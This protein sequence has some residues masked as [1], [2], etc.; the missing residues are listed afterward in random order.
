MRVVHAFPATLG[1]LLLAGCPGRIDDPRPFLQP[2]DCPTPEAIETELL[3]E[4]CAELG[5]HTSG[6]FAAA[7]LDLLTPGA[8]ARI[9]TH[10]SANEDCA[11]LPL[12]AAPDDVDG[13]YFAD[14]LRG[15]Q[16][17]GDPMPRAGDLLQERD[18]ACLLRYVE[19]FLEPGG[20]DAGVPADDGGP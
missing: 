2:V 7:G 20:S 10:V 17:C 19:G 12:V 11:G 4:G 3:R 5:C 9:A 15:T 18:V 8:G 16:S 6:R 1:L 14:K 13:S